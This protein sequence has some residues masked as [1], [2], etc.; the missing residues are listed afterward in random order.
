M[1]SRRHGLHQRLLG[2]GVVVE[3]LVR[4]VG[5]VAGA[6]VARAPMRPGLSLMDCASEGKAEVAAPAPPPD[7]CSRRAEIDVL[8]T[9]ARHHD[10][11]ATTSTF[12]GGGRSAASTPA[13]ARGAPVGPPHRRLPHQQRHQHDDP[14]HEEP[15]D[16]G[17][18]PVTGLPA[19]AHDERTT[20]TIG[21]ARAPPARACRG[22]TACRG[23]CG[24]RLHGSRESWWYVYD[25]ICW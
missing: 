24:R 21:P 17:H 22:P 14:E 12:H 9:I 16:D 15:D 13:G 4:R 19:S 23:P 2:D 18:R 11:A 8:L 5:E 3:T 10:P 7:R 6:V 1:S 20:H 25:F